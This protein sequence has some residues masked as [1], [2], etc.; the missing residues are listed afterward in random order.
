[1]GDPVKYYLQGKLLVNGQFWY[2][3]SV[4][5][6]SN[7][8]FGLT[9]LGSEDE[10]DVR[11]LS[12]EVMKALQEFYT[13][14]EEQSIEENWVCVSCYLEIYNTASFCTVF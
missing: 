11:M 13:E 7:I 9:V 2:T 1:M 14:R 4:V 12:P 3:K 6:K 8:I 10:D 5:R